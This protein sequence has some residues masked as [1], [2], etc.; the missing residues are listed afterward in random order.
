MSRELK[1]VI[2]PFRLSRSEWELLSQ[3]AKANNRPVANW[4]RHV[5]LQAAK[6]AATQGG[7]HA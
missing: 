6:Q 2:V 4:V 3:V 5:A 1:N 7:A